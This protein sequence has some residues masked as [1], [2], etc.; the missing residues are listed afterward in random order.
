GGGGT[1]GGGDSMKDEKVSLVDGV[2]K[3]A[4]GAL[5]FR[6]GSYSG[7]HGGLWWLIEN[8]E[9]DEVVTLEMPDKYLNPPLNL[10]AFAV[11]DLASRI[12]VAEKIIHFV[13][14]S[15]NVI[16]LV[17][18]RSERVYGQHVEIKEIDEFLQEYEGKYDMVLQFLGS[19]QE[20]QD[21]I[22]L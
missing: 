6:N 17:I 5:G 2:F 4:L 3:V 20:I 22:R 7:C 11:F 12:D 21:P 13:Q 14:K 18:E 10:Y 1:L 19:M 16:L 8:E 9:D 15:G